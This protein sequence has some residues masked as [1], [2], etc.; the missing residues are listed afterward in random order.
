M[1]TPKKTIFLVLL[2]FV[3][4]RLAAQ[5]VDTGMYY[6]AD[7]M[8]LRDLYFIQKEKK[9]ITLKNNPGVGMQTFL[10]NEENLIT[11]TLGVFF[12]L[13]VNPIGEHKVML[14]VPNGNYIYAVHNDK[15]RQVNYIHFCD[16]YSLST[17]VVFQNRLWLINGW[18]KEPNIE[19]GKIDLADTTC[20]TPDILQHRIKASGKYRIKSVSGFG[21][22]PVEYGLGETEMAIFLGASQEVLLIDSD[23]ELKRILL[24]RNKGGLWY[25]IYDW[26]AGQHYLIR[27]TNPGILDVFLLDV[28]NKKAWFVQNVE[29][30]PASIIGGT[31]FYCQGSVRSN[32]HYYQ[33]K[34]RY[35]PGGDD[36]EL[37]VLEETLPEW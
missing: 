37:T 33:Q 18:S 5:P 27:L 30:F 3:A 24:P 28:A 23:N 12:L 20:L 21:K 32:C 34:L 31:M 13:K 17:F 19:T 22:Q 6:A 4:I 14:E 16:N 2:F 7:N 26:Q 11:D 35:L 25:Y 10:M 15:A 8:P 36:I 9:I 29:N 1:Q